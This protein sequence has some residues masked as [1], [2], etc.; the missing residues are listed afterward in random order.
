MQLA[1]YN[2]SSTA[3]VDAAKHV[4]KEVED[5][6]KETAALW[7][8]VGK[9]RQLAERAKA[10]AEEGDLKLAGKIVVNVRKLAARVVQEENE[11]KTKVEWLRERLWGMGLNQNTA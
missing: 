6:V 1:A 7:P 5:L 4:K 2:E 9:V 11:V 10:V 8:V 3:V